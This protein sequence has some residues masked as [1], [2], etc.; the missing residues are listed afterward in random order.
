[1]TVYVNRP[2]GR[3]EPPTIQLVGKQVTNGVYSSTNDTVTIN[4]LEETTAH[5]NDVRKREVLTF[6][7]Q[8]EVTL[9]PTTNYGTNSYSRRDNTTDIIGAWEATRG[10]NNEP[11]VNL[12]S[13]TYYT[14]NGKDPTR[15]KANL[16]TGAFTVRRNM[17]GTDNTIIKA[18]TYV[19]GKES[20]VMK[21]EFR[22]IRPRG[23]SV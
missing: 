7:G 20:E 12:E 14:L 1:M 5:G 10:V 9:T 4:T 13:E 2:A 8:V 6:R 18:K 23:N 17:S 21:S 3:V 15:T 19:Q 16:Y 11:Q 22:I